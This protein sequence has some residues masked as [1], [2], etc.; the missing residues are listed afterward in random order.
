MMEI[1]E[2]IKIMNEIDQQYCDI[3]NIACTVQADKICDAIYMAIEALKK[4][5]KCRWHDLR[6]NPDDLPE[7][8]GNDESDYVLVMIGRPEWNHWEQAYYNHAK[9]VWSTYEQNVIAWKAIEPFE[10]EVE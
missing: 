8:D 2:A 10:E 7:K 6:E 1:K 4:A 3:A 9:H 5:E